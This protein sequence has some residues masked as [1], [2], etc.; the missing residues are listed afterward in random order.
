MKGAPSGS[1]E[2]DRLILALNE[3]WHDLENRAYDAKHPDILEAEIPRWERVL[4]QAL[5]GPRGTIAALDL[6]SGT[7]FVPMRLKGFLAEGDRLICSDLSSG[8]LSV[9]RDAVAAGGCRFALETLKLDGKIIDL[10][11]ACLDL[12]TANAVM[13]HLPRPE[14]ACREIDRILKPGGLVLIGHEPT[15]AYGESL[16]LAASYWLLSPLADFKQFIYEII[17]RLGWFE[18]L[19]GPLGRYLPELE[20][21]NR[22][23][24]DVNARLKEKGLI[25]KPL[26]ADTISS[27][28][29]AQSPNAGGPQAGRGFAFSDFEG[30]FPGYR[31]EFRETYT[32]LGKIHPRAR[33]MRAYSRWL[34]RRFPESG[35]NLFCGLRKRPS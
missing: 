28:L 34:A 2:R 24:A 10:P 8:M 33:W 29:D 31:P 9:C 15:R 16:F 35:G 13:H 32:H 12:V 1:G 26:A 5:A 27:L 23:I 22:L 3:I 14:E 4:G 7:G 30:Y 21:H 25:E 19:R 17:L 11:D 18:A 20:A 6:G